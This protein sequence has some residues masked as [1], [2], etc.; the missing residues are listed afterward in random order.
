[1]ATESEHRRWS[2]E[3]VTPLKRNHPL[4]FWTGA[5]VKVDGGYQTYL[6]IQLVLGIGESQSH[7]F[8]EVQDV[9]QLFQIAGKRGRRC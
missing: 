9:L 1:M 4:A 3:Q 7:L 6:I 8:R 2:R 5:V